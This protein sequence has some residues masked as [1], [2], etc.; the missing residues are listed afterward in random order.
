MIFNPDPIAFYIPFFNRPIAWYGI[1]FAVGCMLSLF[2]LQKLYKQF[3]L[4]DFP[5]F[6]DKEKKE[7]LAFHKFSYEKIFLYVMVGAIVGARLFH[8]FFYDWAYFKHRLWEI[9]MTWEGGL[10]SHGAVIGI[11]LSILLFCRIYKDRLYGLSSLFFFDLIA[12]SIGFASFFIRAGNFMNQEIMG[13]ETTLPWAVRFGNPAGA[14]PFVP[15]HPVQLYEAF[16]YLISA[17]VLIALFRKLKNK[18]RGFF[19]GLFL[20]NMFTFRAIAEF[21]KLEQSLWHV[22]FLNMGAILSL[23]I[24]LLGVFFVIYSKRLRYQS[25]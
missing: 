7:I 6:K 25:M 17:F 18:G 1:F 20:I 23:P 8:V 11:V 22:P 19:S 13:T 10:A 4:N 3:L 5:A 12:V 2:V 21:F 9:P 16:F 24:V 14:T 15:R